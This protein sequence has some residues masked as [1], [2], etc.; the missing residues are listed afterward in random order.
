[1]SKQEAREQRINEWLE[2][3]RRCE[4]SG[5]SVVAYAKEHNLRAW[6]LYQWRSRLVREGLW[7]DKARKATRDAQG[8]V[9][10]A[11]FARVTVTSPMPAY[12]MHL[13]L[14]NGRRAEI[15]VARLD[16]LVQLIGA[17]EAQA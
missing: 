9:A 14:G 10:P 6:A 11:P 8:Q 7:P 16:S 3:L 17:L 1:M 15:E 5:G 13:K 12:V 4:A 2:H